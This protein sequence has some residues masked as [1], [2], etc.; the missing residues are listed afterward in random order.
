MTFAKPVPA[1]G[2]TDVGLRPSPFGK[3]GP[4]GAAEYSKRSTASKV[5]VVVPKPDGPRCGAFNGLDND[6]D[7]VVVALGIVWERLGH[8]GFRALGLLYKEDGVSAGSACYCCLRVFNGR[9]YGQRKPTRSCIGSI[10]ID[11]LAVV[12]AAELGG[13]QSAQEVREDGN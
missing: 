5:I 13:V 4:S 7:F 2:D 9:V 3:L 6:E 1:L 12:V 11:C 8:V 10:Y